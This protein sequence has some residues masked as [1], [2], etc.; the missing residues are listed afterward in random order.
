MD[1][2]Q[3]QLA[4]RVLLPLVRLVFFESGH[5]PGVPHWMEIYKTAVN[6]VGHDVGAPRPPFQLLQ[7][8]DEA[9]LSGIL[10]GMDALTHAVAD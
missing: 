7:G 1:A 2:T 6:M 10:S 9:R 3:H 4:I 5:V 8:E